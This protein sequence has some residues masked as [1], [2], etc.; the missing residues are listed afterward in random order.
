MAEK[1]WKVI[2]Q[3]AH[4][5]W[6]INKNMVPAIFSQK[7]RSESLLAGS[8]TRTSTIGTVNNNVIHK[9]WLFLTGG[10]LW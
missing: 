4:P 5:N 3:E 10:L 8:N 2:M 6:E 9:K 1:L 7:F